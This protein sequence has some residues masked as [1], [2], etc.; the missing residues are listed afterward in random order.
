MYIGIDI[1][2]S[3]AAI[4]LV[5]ETGFLLAERQL[6]T[7]Q[8]GAIQTFVQNIADLVNALQEA[9]NTSITGIGIGAPN[10]NYHSGCIEHAP[11]LPWKGIVPLA[12][13]LSATL[14]GIPVKLTND[15]NAAAIGE[16]K[17]GIAKTKNIRDF[18]MITLGTGLGSGVVVGGRLVY[19]HDGFAGELG[20]VLVEPNTGRRCGCGRRGCLER[21]VS[22]TGL[23]LSAQEALAQSDIDSLL[24]ILPMDELTALEV[25]KA[26]MLGDLLALRLFDEAARTLALALANATAVTSPNAFILFGGLAQ[27]GDILIS[28]LKKYFEEFVAMIFRRK[29]LFLQSALPHNTAAILGAAALAMQIEQLIPDN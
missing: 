14:G 22:A 12:E 26:A 24:R 13:M 4:G 15:A 3:H 16:L 5:D 9:F 2:G 11:N 7:P 17:F 25:Y 18:V 6:K 1:G 27:A 8:Y 21:Y 19:G 20:H 29:V 10:G 28:P 23:V